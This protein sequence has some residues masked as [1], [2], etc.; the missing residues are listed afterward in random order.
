MVFWV[1]VGAIGVILLILGAIPYSTVTVPEWRIEVVD[2]HDNKVPNRSVMQTWIHATYESANIFHEE[3]RYTDDSGTV[4]FPERRTSAAS[5]TRVLGHIIEKIDFSQ[6]TSYG[7]HSFVFVDGPG[8]SLTYQ[9]GELP[10]HLIVVE[11]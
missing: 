9:G 1:V 4:I 7:P 5:I 2:Q 3:K 6:H 8:N 10:G 11:E